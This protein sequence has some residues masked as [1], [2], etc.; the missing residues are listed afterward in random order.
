[1][2]N[3]RRFYGKRDVA[4]DYDRQRFGGASGARV[5][6][7]ELALVESQLPPGGRVLDLACGTGRLTRR[8]AALGYQVVAADSSIAM[9]QETTAERGSPSPGVGRRTPSVVG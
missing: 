5:N 7:R 9:V 4:R 3:K 1:M 8:L 2:L 6:Q